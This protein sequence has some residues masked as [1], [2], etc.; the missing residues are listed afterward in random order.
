MLA[1]ACDAE[2]R[3]RDAFAP[4]LSRLETTRLLEGARALLRSLG[5][6]L[7]APARMRVAA[8]ERRWVDAVKHYRRAHALPSSY[9]S[10]ALLRDATRDADRVAHDARGRLVSVLQRDAPA[11]EVHAA[12]ISCLLELGPPD[13]NEPA[14]RDAYDDGAPPPRAAASDEDAEPEGTA[15]ASV[16]RER[17]PAAFALDAQVAHLR[18]HLDE[19]RVGQIVFFAHRACSRDLIWW[20][21]SLSCARAGLGLP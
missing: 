10:I 15:D 14:A 5:G 21:F 8:R 19:A 18:R 11:G 9:R 13:A 3:A 16:L 2:E 20:R 7:D 1:L 12:A 4:L 17:H 6:F